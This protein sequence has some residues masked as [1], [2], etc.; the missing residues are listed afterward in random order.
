MPNSY[1]CEGKK[2]N[3]PNIWYPG[4]VVAF[5]TKYWPAEEPVEKSMESD[6]RSRKH[7]LRRKEIIYFL[8]PVT[9]RNELMLHQGICRHEEIISK[10][11]DRLKRAVVE[12][13]SLQ[14]FYEWVTQ[15]PV[16]MVLVQ[17]IV[18]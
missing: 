3:N 11:W 8:H 17:L 16:K 6:Q 12:Y 4:L 18:T 15:R 13:S 5:Q 10:I 1:C 7:D 2:E 14:F 9:R